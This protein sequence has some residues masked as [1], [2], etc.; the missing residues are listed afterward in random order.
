MSNPPPHENKIFIM[1]DNISILL[2]KNQ[3]LLSDDVQEIIN[4]RPHWFIRKGN[5]I[6]LAIISFLFLLTFFIKYPDV[7]KASARLAAVNAPKM[8]ETKVEGKLEKLFVKNGD[9]ASSGQVLAYIQSTGNHDEVIILKNWISKV[10]PV[11]DTGGFGVIRS[12][13]LPLLTNLGDLQSAYQEFQNTFKETLQILGGGYYQKKRSALEKD[14]QY[15]ATLKNSAKNQKEILQQD[16]GLQQKEYN[17]YE[18]LAKDKVIAPLELN[19]YKSKLLAKDQGLQQ[20]E[21]QIT[22]SDIS[23]HNKRKEILD[24]EKTVV[25]QQQKFKTSLFTLKSQIEEWVQRYIIISP[26]NGRVEFVSFLQENQLL[27]AGQRLFFIQPPKT[28]YY[29]EMKAGQAGFGKIKNG[30]K[31]ILRLNGYPSAEFG[32]IEGKVSYI[33]SLPNERDSFMTKIDLPAGLTTNYKKSIF[34][35]NNLLASA[36]VITDDRRLIDR[37]FGQLEQIVKR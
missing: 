19:Q 2:P 10:E 31:V 21:S 27:S 5:I 32:Y 18:Q 4:Y 37:L 30:Q 22:N 15:L 13:S 26:E 36:E 29:A 7:I 16:Q 12:H 6:F 33:S 11:I 35:R 25:D 8:L 14:L 24:L 17:A 20:T 9:N 28:D 34:F 1:P 23:A 3:Q